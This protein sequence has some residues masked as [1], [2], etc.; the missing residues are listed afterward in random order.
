MDAHKSAFTS[1]AKNRPHGRGIMFPPHSPQ[2]M[3]PGT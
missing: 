1:F 3:L 2:C